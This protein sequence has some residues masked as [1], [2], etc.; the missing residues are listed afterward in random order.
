[1]FLTAG[2]PNAERQDQTQVGRHTVVVLLDGACEFA[3]ALG[4][5]HRGLESKQNFPA[6]SDVH[7]VHSR[8]GRSGVFS[9][10]RYC[11]VGLAGLRPG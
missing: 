6:Q 8:D 11:F 2:D 10:F 5:G 7:K 1:M 3:M 9:A 4:L